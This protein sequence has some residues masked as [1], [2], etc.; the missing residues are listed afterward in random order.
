MCT[1]TIVPYR[2]NRGRCFR[3]AFNRDEER[4]RTLGLP[5]ALFEF[6]SCQAIMPTDPVSGG[7][8]I[9]ANDAGLVLALQNLKPAPPQ[10]AKSANLIS[11]GTIIPGLLSHSCVSQALD[12]LQLR[13]FEQFD[14]FQLIL[15]DLKG[16]A[17]FQWD[18]RVLK[19]DPIAD[20]LEP[21][22]FTTSSLGDEFVDEPRRELFERMFR[23]DAY[24][25]DQQDRF[26]RHHWPDRP[27]LS[28]CM[29]RPDAQ[30]VSLTVIHL[31]P[32]AVTVAYFPGNPDQGSAPIEKQLPLSPHHQARS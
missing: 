18:G 27:H 17:K 15:L 31:E 4:S 13:S 3:V 24:W 32:D 7:T 1:L 19:F 22:L 29:R 21:V 9:A 16:Y 26:H 8:W 30:T 10:L 2:N 28:V 14:C 25:E 23:T 12:A 11:R 6:G 20:V 5:P